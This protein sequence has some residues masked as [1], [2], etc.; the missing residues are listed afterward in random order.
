MGVHAVASF[1][2]RSP[3][4]NALAAGVMVWWRGWIRRTS[5]TCL[6]HGT[7]V[8]GGDLR[9]GPFVTHTGRRMTM[10]AHCLPRE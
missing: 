8:E 1:A 7:Q 3:T 10:E 5:P 2:Q 6:S 9:A 4:V